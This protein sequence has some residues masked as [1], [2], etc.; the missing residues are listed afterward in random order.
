VPDENA[1]GI[2]H[3][4]YGVN[5]DIENSLHE[6]ED[7][8][9][10]SHMSHSESDS[11]AESNVESS[12][13]ADEK[14]Q[15]SETDSEEENA[16]PWDQM[17]FKAYRNYRDKYDELVNNFENEGFSK[18]SAKAAAHNSLLRK[19]RKSLREQLVNQLVYIRKLKRDPIYRKIM[20]TKQD[21]SDLD[22]YDEEE[23]L[24]CA[25]KKRKFLLNRLIQPMD[26]SSSANESTDE[27]G[28]ND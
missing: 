20:K 7:N 28:E 14:E 8:D 16:D 18:N 3:I 1:E 6:V 17:V 5:E 22:D 2:D 19:Y 4:G 11:D 25:V 24:E 13:D 9:D 10:I 21:L 23:A 26:V 15:E 12:E 27:E